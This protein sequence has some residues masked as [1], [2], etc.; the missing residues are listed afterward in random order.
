MFKRSYLNNSKTMT[1]SFKSNLVLDQLVNI[2]SFKIKV[3]F[4]NKQC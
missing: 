4:Y 2:I 3:M 1:Y